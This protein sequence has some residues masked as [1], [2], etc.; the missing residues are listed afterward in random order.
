MLLRIVLIPH[1][2]NLIIFIILG[3]LV[4]H[5]KDLCEA[6]VKPEMSSNLADKPSLANVLPPFETV[7]YS[8]SLIG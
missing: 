1:P 5:R 4:F 3:L 7:I 8:R 2:G 6:R